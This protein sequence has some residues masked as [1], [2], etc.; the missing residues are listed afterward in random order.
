M[1]C[2]S[3]VPTYWE[4]ADGRPGLKRVKARLPKTTGDDV[5][6]LVRAVQEAQTNLLILVD[7]IVS[8]LGDRAR[9]VLDELES[10]LE[11]LLDDNVEEPADAQLAAVKEFHSQNGQRSS[12]LHQS[13]SAYAA[14]AQSLRDRLIQVDEGFNVKLVAEARE[15]ARKLTAAPAVPAPPAFD[16]AGAT[17]TRNR[18]LTLLTGKVALIRKC[19]AHVFKDHPTLVREVT[20]TYERRRRAASRRAKA[21]AETKTDSGAGN[22]E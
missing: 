4:P 13:S 15:L 11:F 22:P 5:I 20:S 10:A 19:A 9:F 2:A 12:A 14:L 16:V 17:R 1:Q 7:L 8:E 18:L 6:S 3:F 21:E